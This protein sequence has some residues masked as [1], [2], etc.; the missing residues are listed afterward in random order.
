MVTMQEADH[1][2]DDP[3]GEEDSKSKKPLPQKRARTSDDG[4]R[5][6]KKGGKSS[7]KRI[8]DM[9]PEVFNEVR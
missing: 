8:L 9:P 4:P 2:E 5:A 3:A 1:A 7:S 6:V